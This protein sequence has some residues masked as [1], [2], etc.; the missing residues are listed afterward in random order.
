ML[1]LL[2]FCLLASAFSIPAAR[3]ALYGSSSPVITLD[4]SSFDSSIRHF[5]VTLVEFYS[6]TCD[7]CTRFAKDFEAT[8]RATMD[9]VKVC[10]VNDPSIAKRFNVTS[11]PTFK[12]FLGR[13]PSGQPDTADYTG[14]L[15][16]ADLVMFTMKNVNKHVKSKVPTPTRTDP[17][18]SAGYPI[19]LSESDFT[20]K[21]LNDTYNQWL[22]MFFAPWCGHCKALHPEWNRMATIANRVNVGSVDATIHSGLAQRYGV[23]G[24]PTIVLLPQG[25]K[26]PSKAIRYNG[27]RKAE[28]ILAFA[29]T[30]Y[31]NMGPPVKVDSVSDL[32]Q[33]CSGPLCL[34]FF[35]PQDSVDQH[36]ST[37]SQVM[38]KNSSLPFE[39]CYTLAGSHPQWE[40]ALGAFS[41]PSLFGL[42][43]TKNV[44]ST[45][46]KEKLTFDNINTFVSEILSGRASAIRLVASLE[47]EETIRNEL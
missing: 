15:N 11:F 20:N 19:T 13:G 23:N 29:K 18:K 9:V 27:A 47:E 35:L 43:L 39:F 26:G 28:E 6:D 36:I 1:K 16:V 2:Q 24:Y 7:S 17:P 32:K 8:A 33:K 46:R 31:R 25:P 5:G 3:S 45:M 12:V 38:E 41:F 4:D 37:I 42:N 14:S 44:Y 21:V 40:R 30:H 10:A 34:L 22:I